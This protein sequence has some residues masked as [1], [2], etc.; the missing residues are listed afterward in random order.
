[1][2]NYT[3][4][5]SDTTTAKIQ[6]CRDIVKEIIGFGVDQS[7]I[8]LILELLAMEIEKHEKSIDIVACIREVAGEDILRLKNENLV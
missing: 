7:Q 6:S 2:T 1:M 3:K 4:T 5:E 8:Y